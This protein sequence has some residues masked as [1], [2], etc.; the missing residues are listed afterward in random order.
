M[1]LHA[2]SGD[3]P[4]PAKREV[5][6]FHGAVTPHEKLLLLATLAVVA[7]WIAFRAASTWSGW[8]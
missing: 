7:A 1:L 3:I 6:A 2:H 8:S 4:K 5:H